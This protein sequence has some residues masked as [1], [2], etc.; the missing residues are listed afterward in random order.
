MDTEVV[1]AQKYSIGKS[2]ILSI[3]KDKIKILADW[4][5]NMPLECKMKI[6][7]TGQKEISILMWEW[8]KDTTTRKVPI[9]GLLQ[10]KAL[11]Y[12]YAW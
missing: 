10:E 1:L 12:A 5:N 4:E 7:K 2:Q 8:F 3:L 9:S 11:A 6:R